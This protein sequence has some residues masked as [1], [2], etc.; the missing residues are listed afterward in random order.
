MSQEI[1]EDAQ[2]RPEI[3]QY[4]DDLACDV[5]DFSLVV[6]GIALAATKISP[7]F[8]ESVQHFALL[9]AGCEFMRQLVLRAEQRTADRLA[10]RAEA[11]AT[12][13]A[14]LADDQE[15]AGAE[16]ASG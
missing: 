4:F 3:N 10:A 5:R 9:A 11:G 2:G 13:L 8:I 12:E 15:G 16:E 6:G 14:G 7:E 1:L